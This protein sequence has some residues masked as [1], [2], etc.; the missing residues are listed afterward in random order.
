MHGFALHF[1]K[2]S[3]CLLSMNLS[4]CHSIKPFS[5][6]LTALYNI[7]T[8]I[9]KINCKKLFP[10]FLY[11][12]V[13]QCDAGSYGNTRRR[14]CEPCA[15][16]CLTCRDGIRPDVCIT[17]FGNAVLYKGVCQPRC[18]NATHMLDLQYSR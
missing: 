16:Q 15:S 17:C 9:I 6:C 4:N 2:F 18:P 11:R 7:F 1:F 14:I 5:K 8:I 12:C 13:T 3:Y 10:L